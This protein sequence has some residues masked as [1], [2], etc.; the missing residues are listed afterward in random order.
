MSK[1]CTFCGFEEV[2][3]EGDERLEYYLKELAGR[4]ICELCYDA[5]LL[6]A[7]PLGEYARSMMES[8]ESIINKLTEE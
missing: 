4:D 2:I 5:G 3:K 1:T 7:G 6:E 8:S